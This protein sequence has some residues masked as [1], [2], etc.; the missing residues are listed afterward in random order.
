M[1]E[2]EEAQRD[3][4]RESVIAMWAHIVCLYGSIE[5]R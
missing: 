1:E 4:R 3:Y 2:D 5:M